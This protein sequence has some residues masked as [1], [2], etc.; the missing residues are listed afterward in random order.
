MLTLIQG[1]AGGAK[2]QVA[3]ELLAAGDI[4]VLADV[5]ALWVALSELCGGLTAVT[6]SAARTMPRLWSRCTLRPSWRAGG[7]K[8]AHGSR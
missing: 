8:R 3:A 1:P 5:T 2:S 7:W 4:D 6:R